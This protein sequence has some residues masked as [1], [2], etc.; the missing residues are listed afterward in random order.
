MRESAWAP[1]KESRP[2]R[3]AT[4]RSAQIPWWIGY[5]R[6]VVGSVRE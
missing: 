3:D 6:L 2:V 4:S 1:H 5:V